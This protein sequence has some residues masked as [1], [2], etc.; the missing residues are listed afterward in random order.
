MQWFNHL[1]N[2]VTDLL[3]NILK[4]LATKE[5]Y[6]CLWDSGDQKHS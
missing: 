6:Y 3:I 1:A 5:I 2:K 4:H